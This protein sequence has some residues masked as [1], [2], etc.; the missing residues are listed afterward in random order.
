MSVCEDRVVGNTTY[1]RC[2]C[3]EEYNGDGYLNGTR[4][5]LGE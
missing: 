5:T 3:P 1:F 4:C 2:Y